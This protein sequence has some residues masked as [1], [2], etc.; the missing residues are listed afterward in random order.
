MNQAEE[1]HQP[2]VFTLY[3]DDVRLV[4]EFPRGVHV[5]YEEDLERLIGQTV[6]LFGEERDSRAPAE[7]SV[8]I[9]GGR[10]A[11]VGGTLKVEKV[12]R[13]VGRGRR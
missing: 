3:G 11:V 1:E 10:V 6:K 4:G 12:T 8:T 2:E 9:D 5:G 7:G 13:H